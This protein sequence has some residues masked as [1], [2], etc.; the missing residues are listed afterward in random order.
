M[1]R[2]GEAYDECFFFFSFFFFFFFFFG[3]F[4]HILG[5]QSRQSWKLR[6]PNYF[7]LSWEFS[8]VFRAVT[9]V[10]GTKQL[11]QYTVGEIFV[12]KNNV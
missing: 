11:Q 9:F 7:A 12:S 1:S 10:R 5:P 8:V 4:E 3:T 6:S 2:D